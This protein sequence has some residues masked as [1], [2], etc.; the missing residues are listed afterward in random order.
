MTRLRQVLPAT[1]V[2]VTFA[3]FLPALSG[4]FLDWDDRVNLVQNEG[5][6]GLGWPQIRWAFTSTL[7]GHYIPFAWLTLSANYAAGGLNPWSYH[8]LNLLLHSANALLFYLVAGR[9]LA[10]AAHG[11]SQENRREAPIVWSAAA[12]ALIFAV[13]PLR[14]ESVAWVTERRDVLSGFFFLL[15]VLAYLRSVDG[16]ASAHRRWLGLSLASF[17]A[18]LLSKAS[19]MVLPA[20]LVLLDVY[21]LRRGAFAWRRLLG[22]KAGHWVLGAA[23]AAGALLALKISGIRVTSYGAYGPGAR[24]AMVAYSLWFYP[25]AWVWP[26]EL[27]PLYELPAHVDP[28]AWRFLGSVVGFLAITLALVWLRQRWPAGLAAWAYSALVLLPVSGVVHAG[29]QLAHD[30]YS[31]LSGLGFALV[32]GGAIG[33]VLRAAGTGRISRAVQGAVVGVAALVILVLGAGTWQQTRIWRDSETLWRWT[34]QVDPRCAVCANNLASLIVNK[35]SRD[36]A[37]IQ[38]AEALA[39]TA[40]ATNPAYD[41]PYTTLGTIL[42]VLKRDAEAE[43]AFREAMR[44]APDRVSATANLGALYARNGRYAEA[45]P[46]LRAAGAMNPHSLEWRTNLGLALRNYGIERARDGRLAEATALLQETAG[47]IPDDADTHRT[48]GLALWEQGRPDQARIHLERALALR[49]NAEDVR[50]L[51]ARLREDPA[52]PPSKQ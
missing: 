30:R 22:E 26:V 11:G 29:F 42:A 38:E 4:E 21:P 34:L 32:A 40:I 48:L 7:M 6:R 43:A 1:V 37:Q 20:V 25:S 18:G 16:S 28:L 10:A 5:Y 12:A 24:L 31:Y 45:L 3:V 13:H 39:R 35:P 33:W 51:L 19:V 8:L 41:S 14:V 2:L 9:L 36:A 49:P 50:Q 46:L 23:G 17:A 52:R 27:S 47:L 44:L 15:S